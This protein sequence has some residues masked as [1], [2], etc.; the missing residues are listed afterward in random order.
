MNRRTFL[1]VSS[2][3]TL[4]RVS[5]A[6]GKG[7]RRR[8]AVIGHTGR[9]NYGHGLDTVWL[10]FPGVEVVAVADADEAGLLKAVK[11]LEGAEGF[12]DYRRMLAEVRPEFVSVCPRHADQH[13]AMALAAIEA[14]AR[15]VYVE[16][17]FCRTPAEADALVRAC[18]NTGARIAVAHGVGG[19]SVRSTVVLGVE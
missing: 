6:D 8:V 10:E 3:A 15:G 18:A 13:A 12:S 4:S 7:S 16:K 11:R 2:S 17:P 9:G 14:G 5:A 1:A 19:I